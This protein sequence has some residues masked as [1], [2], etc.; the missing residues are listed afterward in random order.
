MKYI[1]SGEICLYNSSLTDVSRRRQMKKELNT[2]VAPKQESTVASKKIY[3]KPQVVFS[4]PLEAVAGFC[5][6]TGSGIGKMNAV[7]CGTGTI[8]S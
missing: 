8:N 3:E 5:D 4:S 6:P 2:Q 1:A 7:A